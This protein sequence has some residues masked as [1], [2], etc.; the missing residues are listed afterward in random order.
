MR[1][2]WYSDAVA[3]LDEIYEY[4]YDLNPRA[5]AML[6]NNILKDAEVLLIQPFIAPIEPLEAMLGT[7]PTHQNKKLLKS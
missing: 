3:D 7:S 5:A 6:F 2:L 1:L 4:Y